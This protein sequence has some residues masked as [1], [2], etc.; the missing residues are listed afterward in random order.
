MFV[1]I[2]LVTCTHLGYWQLWKDQMA[3]CNDHAFGTCTPTNMTIAS[4]WITAGTNHNYTS[5]SKCHKYAPA[6]ACTHTTIIHTSTSAQT[7]TQHNTHTHTH[8]HCTLQT[9]H[10]RMPTHTHA[11][12]SFSFSLLGKVK[13]ASG[14]PRPAA[15]A[16]W[17]IYT[18]EKSADRCRLCMRASTTIKTA[19]SIL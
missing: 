13:H 3:D 11:P 17:G 14:I 7:H 4:M 16:E 10:T 2:W 12:T 18:R 15:T 19:N 8:T 5:S 9:H 6:I 1:V